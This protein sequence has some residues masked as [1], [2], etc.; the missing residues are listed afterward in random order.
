VRSSPI[1]KGE[2][3]VRGSFPALGDHGEPGGRRGAG[4]GSPRRCRY[5]VP[6]RAVVIS[7]DGDNLINVSSLVCIATHEECPSDITA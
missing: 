6:Y 4:G 7:A 2:T 5:Y 3:A 1:S